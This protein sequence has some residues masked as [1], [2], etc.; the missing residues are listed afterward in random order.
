MSETG[1]ARPGWREDLPIYAILL[2]LLVIAASVLYA[3]SLSRPDNA[4]GMP[5]PDLPG[6]MVGGD[7]A[8]RWAPIAGAVYVFHTAFMILGGLLFYLGVPVHRRGWR[9]TLVLAAVTAVMLLVTH[10]LHQSYTLFLETGLTVFMGGFPAPAFLALFA[11]WGA[12]VLYD[13]LF[14]VAFRHVFLNAEDE[15]AFNAL[16]AEMKALR[17]N[18]AA[19]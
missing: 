11:T 2:L 16:A 18:G 6:M 13:I 4:A 19:G 5:H 17:E 15:A 3:V 7:G 12:Y 10:A 9:I 8:A 1:A 14:V